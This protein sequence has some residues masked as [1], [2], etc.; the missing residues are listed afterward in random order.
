MEAGLVLASQNIEA[1]VVHTTDPQR[2][3]LVVKPKDLLVARAQLL[4]YTRENRHRRWRQSFAGRR[5]EF[6][7][8]SLVW[9]FLMAGCYF[10]QAHGSLAIQS[11]GDFYSP[12]VRS[13]EWWR[14]VTAEFLH[15]DLRHLASNAT[16]GLL[17]FGVAMAEYG[18]GTALLAATLCGALANFAA[19]WFRS[20]PYHGL[21]ASGM[22]M[23]ALGLLAVRSFRLQ[24]WRARPA[25]TISRG[26]LAGVFLF[27]LH[28]FNPSSDVLVHTLGFG[29]GAAAGV[30]LSPIAENPGRQ[31]RWD[32][33]G[34]WLFVG[35]V[36]VAWGC[37]LWPAAQR[38]L[39]R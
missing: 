28:G 39:E 10:F 11:L 35:V 36:A 33:L 15:V 22:V 19:M 8:Q 17:F 7:W 9:V 37:A 24:D 34:K 30:L 20:M 23:A 16:T 29:L 4:Q 26:F 32:A 18:A 25:L 14:A 12:A 27:I 2:W 1:A 6:D 31:A 21:G 5:F 3:Q 38:G 13:G